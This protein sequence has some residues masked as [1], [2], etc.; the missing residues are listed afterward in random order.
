MRQNMTSTDQAHRLSLKKMIGGDWED[1]QN[2]RKYM[3]AN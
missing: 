1:V 3:E 2:H